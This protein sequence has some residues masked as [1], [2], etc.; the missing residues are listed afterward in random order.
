MATLPGG[1]IG[2]GMGISKMLKFHVKFF[3]MVDKVI[4]PVCGQVLYCF[5]RP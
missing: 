3:Y 4:F 5:C 1:G 2:G